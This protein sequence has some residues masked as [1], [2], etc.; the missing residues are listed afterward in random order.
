MSP[1]DP[2][3]APDEPE[4]EAELDELQCALQKHPQPRMSFSQLLSEPE[5]VYGYPYPYRAG[6]RLRKAHGSCTRFSL[7]TLFFI[8]VGQLQPL[9]NDHF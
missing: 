2:V 4:P 7:T 6:S 1:E 9:R 5:R 3:L 8:P